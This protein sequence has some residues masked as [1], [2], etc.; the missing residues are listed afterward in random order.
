MVRRK[1]PEGPHLADVDEPRA[2][3][4]IMASAVPSPV[5]RPMRAP[6]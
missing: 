2:S 3:F 4:I 1:V 5:P 6:A